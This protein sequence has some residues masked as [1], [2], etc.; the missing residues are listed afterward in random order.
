MNIFN[1]FPER[2]YLEMVLGLK[3]RPLSRI[4]LNLIKNLLRA[5][6]QSY[7]LEELK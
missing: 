3:N 5:R 1:S 7:G 4:P 6:T 2:P